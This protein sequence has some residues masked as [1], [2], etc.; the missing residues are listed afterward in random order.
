MSTIVSAVDLWIPDH[1]AADPSMADKWALGLTTYAEIINQRRKDNVP[2]EM[3]YQNKLAEPSIQ[4]WNGFVNP[5][6]RSKA[7]RNAD[8]IK[9]AHN[10]NIQSGYDQ[11]SGRLDNAFAT[12][13][14]V[15]AKH[16]KDQVAAS[17]PY[18]TKEVGGKVMRLVGDRVRGE[19]ATT[20][21]VYWLTG[22]P[23]TVGM[24]RPQDTG[25]IGGP[26][27]I[28]REDLIQPFKAALMARLIQGGMAI[29][30]SDYGTALITQENASTNSLVQGFVD[31]ALG[32]DPFTTG[33]TSHLDFV[34]VGVNLKLSLQVSRA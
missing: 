26:Y 18:W 11:W 10:K 14:G 27:R 3:A 31:P 4:T 23:M 20:I 13:D 34:K 5:S 2:N 25:V 6:F 24:L 7:G 21:A 17:K 1:I 22:E 30:N 19:G 32:I 28:G 12:V 15:I 8:K 33:G 9:D 29:L 16:F